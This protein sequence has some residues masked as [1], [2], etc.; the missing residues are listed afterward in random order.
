[1]EEIIKKIK[2]NQL[3]IGLN[4]D[5]IRNVLKEI[6]YYIK[7]YSKGEIIAHEDDECRSLSLVLF[8]TVEIQ[9]LYSNGKYIVLSR[10]L[11]G[12]VFGEAL[13]FSKSKT[14]PATVIALNECK[15]LFINKEDV[16]KICSYEE[17]VLENFISLLSDKVFIL[18]SKIKSISFK[19]LRQKVINYIL[20]EI[21]EQK[22][23]SIILNNTKEEIASLLG[24][25]RPSLS[26]ELISLRDLGYIEFDRKIIRVLDVES[27][28]EEL[29]N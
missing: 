20:N 21:K 18:N 12:E 8:G 1:M 17:K 3:F 16:L 9:R 26:R 7:T 6:K 14:Y 23:N 10:L 24:I 15:V 29:F 5:G 28:E 13:V 27:L 22:S 11:E 19:S 25:P 4:D 2:K